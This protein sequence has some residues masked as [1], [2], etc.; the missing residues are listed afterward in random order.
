MHGQQSKT[1][2][3]NFLSKHTPSP[4]GLILNYVIV[5]TL[6]LT[7]NYVVSFLWTTICGLHF[8]YHTNIYTPLWQATPKRD[9]ILSQKN[10]MWRWC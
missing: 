2:F 4:S 8:S 9:P 7:H 10:T 6:I 5:Y 3:T 1:R